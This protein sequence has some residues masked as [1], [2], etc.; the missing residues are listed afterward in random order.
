MSTSRRI[1]LFFTGVLVACIGVWL[2]SKAH[3]SLLYFF[4]ARTGTAPIILLLLGVGAGGVAIN[5]VRHSY[6]EKWPYDHLLPARRTFVLLID[7]CILAAVF[8]AIFAAIG[9]VVHMNERVDMVGMPLVALFVTLL[10]LGADIVWHLKR[11]GDA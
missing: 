4:G 8:G 3:V 2:G 7:V 11:K 10:L 9:T 5:E 1:M 6:F